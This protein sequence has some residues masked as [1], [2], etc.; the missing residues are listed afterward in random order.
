MENMEIYNQEQLYNEVFDMED[1]EPTEEFLEALQS[2]VDTGLYI[3]SKVYE[4][5]AIYFAREGLKWAEFAHVDNRLKQRILLVFAKNPKTFFV[6]YNTQKGKMRIAALE[7]KAWAHEREVKPVA[8][9]IVDND[10][11]LADQSE[12]GLRKLIGEENMEVFLLSSNSSIKYTEIEKHIDAYDADRRNKY[13][14]PVIVAL[15]NDKQM[16]KVVS[17]MKYIREVMRDGSK[18]RYG[19]IFDEADKIYPQVRDKAYGGTTLQHLVVDDEQALYKLGFVTATHGDLLDTKTYPECAN[20]HLY[21]TDS[22][23][24]NYRA[25]HHPDS[26]IKTVKHPV[27][28]DNNTYAHNILTTNADYFNT[29]VNGYCR[30]VIVNSNA[31]AEKMGE[32]AKKCVEL[33][34]YAITFNMNGI[35]VYGQGAPAKF[36][37]KGRKFNEVLFYVYKTL[38]LHD[39]PLVII[40]RRKVDRGLGFHYAPRTHDETTIVGPDGDLVTRDGEGLIWTDIILGRI[41]DN[42]TAVQKAGRGAGIIAQCPQYIGSVTYWTDERTANTIKRHNQIVDTAN[43]MGTCS[44]MQ[45]VGHAEEQ[46]PKIA[47][48]RPYEL[49]PQSF[50]TVEEA[51]EWA[52]AHTPRTYKNSK[53][54][55]VEYG[56][57][58]AYGLYAADGKTK[59]TTHILYRKDPR[60]I[61]TEA[62]VR[63]SS[64]LGYGVASSARVMPVYALPDA[65]DVALG[66]WAKP[67]IMPIL[68][69]QPATIKYIVIYHPQE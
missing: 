33:N 15:A 58:S 36:T 49:S 65:A 11:T 7:I 21:E 1:G 56:R 26:V 67:R 3:C 43:S 51:K 10:K 25:L 46:H 53:G 44:V 39:K 5:R 17:L 64:D 57:P 68:S 6:L 22:G 61:L 38:K 30:K 2:L 41:D 45:A 18:L 27:A 47:E 37:A 28:M 20:A 24:I 29:P 63:G 32:F 66:S 4:D 13:K 31:T 42:A 50:A 23:D 34:M 40:G 55:T 54:E 19:I 59:G 60:P 62:E 16:A 52:L 8:F 48:R 14:M 9:V 12:D 69:G 35:N